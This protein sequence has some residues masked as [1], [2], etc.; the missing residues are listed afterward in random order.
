MGQTLGSKEDTDVGFNRNEKI[1]VEVSH[2][3]KGQDEE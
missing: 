1:K 2:Y 3:K